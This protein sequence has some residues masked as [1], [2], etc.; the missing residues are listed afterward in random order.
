MVVSNRNFLFQGSIFRGYVS[1][2]FR[3][4]TPLKIN[5]LNLKVMKVDRS[6]DLPLTKTD[7]FFMFFSPF[8]FQGALCLDSLS[9]CSGTYRGE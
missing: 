4:G 9:V 7:D 8:I 3:E 6:D 2:S 1:F 5:P